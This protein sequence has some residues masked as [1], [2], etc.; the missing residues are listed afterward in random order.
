MEEGEERV[1]DAPDRKSVTGFGGHL[2]VVE[3]PCEFIEE[4]LKPET[5]KINNATDVKRGDLYG[6]FVLFAG[7]K[8]DAKGVCNS[9]VDYV[10]YKP[11]A[12]CTPSAKANPCGRRKLLHLRLFS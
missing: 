1:E 4:W 12:A 10:I 7:C 11:D 9:E 5:P 2:I 6:A 3:N 8:P